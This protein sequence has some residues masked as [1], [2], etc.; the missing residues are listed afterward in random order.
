MVSGAAGNEPCLGGSFDLWALSA[1]RFGRARGEVISSL[2]RFT[3]LSVATREDIADEAIERAWRGGRLD[4]RGNPVAYV[5]KIASRLAL[6][7]AHEA[8]TVDLVESYH[9][10]EVE[11]RLPLS[12]QG[13]VVVRDPQV[14]GPSDDEEL[15][16]AAHAAIAALPPSQ[17]REVALLRSQDVPAVEIANRL[18]ISRNQVDQQWA[19]GR[20][21]IREIPEIKDR[22]RK[23]HVDRKQARNGD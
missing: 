4:P 17:M 2:G 12:D 9:T 19:R 1:P 5:K 22:L 11:R 7:V 21:R 20:Q 6:K 18:S 15:I 16:G 10:L 13:A 3:Q 14:W 8:A 23:A